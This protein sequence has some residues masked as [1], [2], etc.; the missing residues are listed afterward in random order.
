MK[1]SFINSLIST[2]WIGLVQRVSWLGCMTLVTPIFAQQTALDHY[3]AKPDFNYRYV[4]Y[5]TDHETGY[6]TYFLQLT[7]QQ[8][9]STTEVDRVLWQ[10]DISITVPQ[11]DIPFLNRND[12]VILLIDG[13]KAGDPVTN[14]YEEI[15][16]AFALWTGSV[17]ARVRQIP[18]QPL[19][20][21]DELGQRRQ[22]DQILAYSLDK[23]LLTGDP[24]WIVH[25]PMTKAV[26]RTMDAIQTFLA[27]DNKKVDHFLLL[28]GSK[29]G[30]TAWLTAA[31]DARVKAIAP[32][33]IDMLNLNAQFRHHWEAY[34]FY[35]PAIIDYARFDLPC[36][37]Q[38]ALGRELLAIADPYYYRDRLTIPKLIVNS[39]G[40]QFFLPDSSQ[41]YYDDL[42]NPKILRYTPNTD[43]RQNN[44]DILLAAVSWI[45]NAVRRNDPP[46]YQWT[47]EADGT[48]RVETRSR[49]R[50]VRL[51][52]A[53]NP[54]A[55]DFR[56]ESV[57]AIWRATPLNEQGGGI[58]QATV[59]P[60]A[61][62]FTAFFI[63]LTFSEKDF[64]G[65][66]QVYTTAVRIVPD[67]LPF[68]G[69]ACLPPLDSDGDGVPN[70]IEIHQGTRVDIKD[71][72]IFNNARRFVQQ[73]H[74]DSLL[75]EGEQQRV[76]FLTEQLASH[77]LKRSELVAEL[78]AAAELQARLAPIIR[79]YLATFAR[80]PDDAG[81]NYWLQQ[82]DHGVSLHTIAQ[83][84][85]DS[86]ELRAQHTASSAQFVTYLYQTILNRMPDSAGLSYWTEQL[87]HGL[88]RGDLLLSFSE[89]LEYR[90][91]SAANVYITIL[92]KTLLQRIPDAA[93]FAYWQTQRAN[94]I[95]QSMMIEAFLNSSEYRQ[96]FV[97][98]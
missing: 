3:I 23:Y 39:A 73:Q 49:P 78:L 92:Y 89:S 82:Y 64:L 29:R 21:A 98:E 17:V 90:S 52:Q 6:K 28:G 51:W 76:D 96:R 15:A 27:A 68:T 67:V 84:F 48:I 63:E 10:H 47:F 42:L 65:A 66:D 97:T 93:G 56:L 11:N 7:S 33:S 81:F 88:T 32:A 94:G 85:A 31:V 35:A 44:R 72:D 14:D 26:V 24:E 95:S 80:L 30:W 86:D 61:Q 87:D 12:W 69:T 74:R 91:Q 46:H 13:G 36:R 83:A 77:A 70:A 40:D 34:G 54:N 38:R 20:F 37:A 25:L 19:Y 71:N 59:S 58:Y 41:F 79:L 16:G 62:G 50:R 55:R 2:G 18:N 8:W 5:R 9:R 22:E 43:H 45:R 75:Y 4:H 53:T 60:P 1:N 57:G